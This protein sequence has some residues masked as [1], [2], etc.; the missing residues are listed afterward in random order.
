MSVVSAKDRKDAFMRDFKALLKKHNAELDIDSVSRGYGDYDIVA[1]VSM[2][3]EW[4]D[5]GNTTK[6]SA[7]FKLPL[8]SNGS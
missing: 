7:Y 2:H 8:W 4:D 5:S 3:G 1:E 6:E